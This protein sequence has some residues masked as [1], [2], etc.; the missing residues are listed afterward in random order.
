MAD[1]LLEIF[2]R[3]G[4]ADGNSRIAPKPALR[5]GRRASDFMREAPRPAF[6]PFGK[7][8]ASASSTAIRTTTP[9]FVGAHQ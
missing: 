8:C 7:C 5:L 3:L 9:I 6:H 1:P 2:R 4:K